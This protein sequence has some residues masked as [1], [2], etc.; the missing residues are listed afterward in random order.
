MIELLLESGANVNGG[1]FQQPLAA[2]SREGHEDVVEL[3]LDRGADVN[4]RVDAWTPLAEASRGGWKHIAELLL[5]RGANVDGHATI[6]VM[7]PLVV[8][9]R[10]GKKDIVRLL[11]E[12]GATAEW[13]GLTKFYPFVEKDDREAVQTLLRNAYW[14]E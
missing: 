5:D 4:G 7:T 14:A 11:L 8:A 9:S 12:R 10:A 13:D 6:L 2:A 3:L 1:S